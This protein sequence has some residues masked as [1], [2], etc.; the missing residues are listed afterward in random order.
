MGIGEYIKNHQPL[1]YRTFANALEKG[2]LS[3]AYLL[4]GEAGIPLKET[5]IYL[6]K[7]ILCDHPSPFADLT[8]RTCQRIDASDYPDF[9]CLD[10]SENSIKK[11]EVGNVLAN[12]NQ[13]ALERKGIMVYVIHEVENMTIEAINSLLKFLEEPSP[14]TFAILT[15]RNESKVLPTIISRCESLRMLLVPQEQVIQ[16]ATSIGVGKNDAEI[17]SF[18]NNDA[19]LIAEQVETTD[20]QNAKLAFETML[21]AFGEKPEYARYVMEKT[22][23]PLIN[24]KKSARF[25][26]DMLAM[27]FEDVASIRRQG[28]IHLSSYLSQTKVIASSIPNPDR[29]LLEVMTLRGE[30]DTNIN[31]GLLFTHLIYVIYKE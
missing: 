12:F 2:R 24:S 25:Y 20:Y 23:I 13:T 14:N 31:L 4:M 9:V 7:S 8:C 19:S 17:L 27:L 16:E 3:H 11:D 28:R 6:A 21:E 15:T 10:G 26:L 22:I 5:A 30:I 29:A 1:A 18:F